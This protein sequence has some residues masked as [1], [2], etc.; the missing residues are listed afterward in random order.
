[1]DG[2]L[3][4]RPNERIEASYALSKTLWERTRTGELTARRVVA[5]CAMSLAHEHHGSICRLVQNCNY[6]SATALLRPL[7]ESVATTAWATYC[8]TES[9]L[10]SLIRLQGELPKV[11]R[12]THLLGRAHPGIFDLEKV[13]DGNGKVL[14]S[15]THGGIEQL[16]RRM[17]PTG[18][19]YTK[20]ENYLTVC[21]ADLFLLLAV[22][23]HAAWFDDPDLDG[24]LRDKTDTLV[25]DMM[26]RFD[27][28]D[29]LPPWNGWHRLPTPFSEGLEQVLQATPLQ[30]ELPAALQH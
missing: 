17:R 25:A 3:A 10:L 26:E 16:R 20:D 23:I 19:P 24:I 11:T 21:L 13:L 22:S 30:T 12:M 18:T 28:L 2:R 8:A 14:H 29:S 9:K 5:N 27:T 7:H 4:A 1:M 15:M 6:A